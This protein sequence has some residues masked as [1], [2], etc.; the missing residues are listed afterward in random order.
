MLYSTDILP[1]QALKYLLH[2]L[3]YSDFIT[4]ILLK[5]LLYCE[6]QHQHEIFTRS[7]YS[8]Y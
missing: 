4:E 6:N 3:S 1:A 8:K 7:A 2:S 5:I